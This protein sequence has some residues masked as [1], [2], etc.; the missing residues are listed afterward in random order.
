[1][2]THLFRQ[3]IKYKPSANGR[4]PDTLHYRDRLYI[5]APKSYMFTPKWPYATHPVSWLFGKMIQRDHFF[6]LSP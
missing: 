2:P 3:W 6:T 1:M 5:L 4:I